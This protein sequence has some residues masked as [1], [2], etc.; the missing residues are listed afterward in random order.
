MMEGLASEKV[1]YF[2]MAMGVVACIAASSSEPVSTGDD[3]YVKQSRRAGSGTICSARE[4]GRRA[5]V[6]ALPEAAVRG[7]PACW[8]SA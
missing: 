7:M 1:E 6:T 4:L 8:T 2:N 3:G 5:A